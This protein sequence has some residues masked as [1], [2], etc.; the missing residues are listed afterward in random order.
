MDIPKAIVI[1]GIILG[2]AYLLGNLYKMHATA[3]GN[4]FVVNS[5]TGAIT[6]CV[7]S[8][9]QELHTESQEEAKI[10]EAADA[11]LNKK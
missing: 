10:R 8:S 7:P 2:A 11:I 5:I 4:A 9:C 3:R 1:S 6:H